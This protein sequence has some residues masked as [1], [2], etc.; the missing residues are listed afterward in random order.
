MLRREKEPD[1]DMMLELLPSAA[2]QMRCA[3]CDHVG[4]QVNPTDGLDDGDW[5]EARC[6]E[7]CGAAISPERLKVFPDTQRCPNCQRADEQGELSGEREFCEKCGA[8]MV[9]RRS[10]GAGITRYVS[11][12]SECGRK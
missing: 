10:G 11:V 8:L 7:Q 4:M 3:E 1:I 5:G 9:L 6:C 2:E 12:C